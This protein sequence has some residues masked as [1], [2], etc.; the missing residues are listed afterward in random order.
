VIDCPQVTKGAWCHFRYIHNFAQFKWYK[1]PLKID[2][3]LSII[4]KTKHP[5]KR[6][7]KIQDAMTQVLTNKKIFQRGWTTR[8][9]K[10]LKPPYPRPPTILRR[11]SDLKG[12]EEHVKKHTDLKNLHLQ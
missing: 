7:K 3:N 6:E 9:V 2:E 5:T 10:C 11:R 8:E 4:N 1:N 12:R